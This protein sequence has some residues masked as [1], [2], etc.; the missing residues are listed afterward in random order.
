MAHLHFELKMNPL[1]KITLH[2]LLYPLEIRLNFPTLP[3]ALISPPL[4][5]SNI[6]ININQKLLPVKKLLKLRMK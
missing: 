6:M 2:Q 5:I 1:I 4:H 3:R